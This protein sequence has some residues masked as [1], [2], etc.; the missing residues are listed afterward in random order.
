MVA[1]DKRDAGD[2]DLL[3]SDLQ[4]FLKGYENFYM[5]RFTLL[6]GLREGFAR[7]H[8]NGRVTRAICCVLFGLDQALFRLVPVTRNYTSEFVLVADKP[9]DEVRG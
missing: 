5:E 4:E 2:V 7:Y 1:G 8:D 6:E 9:V 3:M